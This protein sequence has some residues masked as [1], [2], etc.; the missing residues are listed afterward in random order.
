VTLSYGVD[1]SRRAYER[2]IRACVTR[3]CP[4]GTD[5]A[6]VFGGE[7]RL[8]DA[9]PCFL[10]RRCPTRARRRSGTSFDGGCR[11]R[12]LCGFAF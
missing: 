4:R 12:L 2:R 5:A 7:L 10:D 6:V 3:R 1:P 9:A 8:L 11:G